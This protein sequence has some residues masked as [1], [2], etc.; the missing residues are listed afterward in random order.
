MPASN[1]TIGVV[2]VDLVHDDKRILGHKIG[3]GSGRLADV[4]PRLVELYDD[5]RL[6]LDELIS[7]RYP[8][9][10]INEAIASASGGDALRNVIV[11]DGHGVPA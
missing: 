1:E 5:G 8:L 11:F 9:E 10:E 3:S 7:G 4:V 6:R 2:G